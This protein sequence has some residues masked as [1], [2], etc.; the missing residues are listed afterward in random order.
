MLLSNSPAA[1]LSALDIHV[2][3]AAVDMRASILGETSKI[4]IADQH[5]SGGEGIVF[6]DAVY[7]DVHEVRINHAVL[8]NAGLRFDLRGTRGGTLRD[9]KLADVCIRNFAAPL[10]VLSRSGRLGLLPVAQGVNFSDVVVQ[11]RGTL[12]A[13]GLRSA[14]G[15][16]CPAQPGEAAPIRWAVD[17]SA[18]GRPGTRT[19]LIVAQDGSGD[20]KTI[21]GALEALPVTGGDIA[22]KPGTYR[23]VV[24]IRKP[25]VHLHGTVSNAT[26]TEIVFD[27]AGPR[28]NGTFNSATVSVEADNDSIDN[29]TIA[30]DAGIGKGQAVALA[31][32]GDRATF[33]NVRLPGAQDTLFAASRYCYGDYGPCEPARQYFRDCYIAGNVDFIFGD[34]LAVFDHCELHGIPGRVMYTAQDRHTAAQKS[35]YV[36]DH[37]RLTA[38]PA[39]QAITLGRPWRPY[40]TVVYLHSQI[41]APVVPVGWTEWPRFGV[42]SLP[43][44]YYA[45]FD[46]KGL[47]ASP[48][49]R[50]P[51]S[52]QLTAEQAAQWLPRKILAGEDGWNPA[53]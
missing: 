53:Q 20:F 1:E 45:E 32:T 29:M 47:G 27:R 18:A 17:T 35:A 43:L 15:A 48:S 23:E 19:M 21:D 16:V 6:G 12:E 50:E 34:G 2:D 11:G 39:S 5:A 40:A 4:S 36:F 37:C 51:Y 24:T 25:H 10:T 42:P 7:G 38:D 9:V 41:D 33:R 22:V 46:S 31:V 8:E 30:N 26:G 44:A 13:R 49:A 14:A 3:G 28:S 52:H